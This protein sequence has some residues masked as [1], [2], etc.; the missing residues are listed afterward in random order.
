[1]T[2]KELAKKLKIT[3]QAVSKLVRRGMPTVSADAAQ[4]WRQ[5]NAQRHTRHMMT[6]VAPM[7]YTV[8]A[9]ALLPD[10]DPLES[11]TAGDADFELIAAGDDDIALDGWQSLTV[12]E[13]ISVAVA[14]FLDGE[15][16]DIDRAIPSIEHAIAFSKIANEV[17]RYR[18]RQMPAEVAAAANPDNPA[19]AKAA[20]QEWLAAFSAEMFQPD[21]APALRWPDEEQPG[22]RAT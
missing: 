9:S 16:D 6:P 8:A 4:F 3:R 21:Y 20:L 19:Q 15:F 7:R 14:D 12:D 18:L 13:R 1:M 2:H 17:L 11:L 22:N 10:D 5:R